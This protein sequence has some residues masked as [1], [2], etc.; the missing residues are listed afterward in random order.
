MNG[1]SHGYGAADHSLPIECV[2]CGEEKPYNEIDWDEWSWERPAGSI[3][4]LPYCPDCPVEAG[5][6]PEK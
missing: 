5:D 4:Q 1:T 3:D 2:E 6:L